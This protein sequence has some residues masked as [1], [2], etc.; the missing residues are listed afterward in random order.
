MYASFERFEIDMTKKQAITCSHPGSCDLDVLIMLDNPKIKRQLNKI[1]NELL[2]AELSEYGAW[3]GNELQDRTANEQRIVWIA[4]GNIIEECG[5][6]YHG[7]R[8]GF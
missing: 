2:A 6:Y 1:S 7:A 8:K 5:G 3:D 4:A